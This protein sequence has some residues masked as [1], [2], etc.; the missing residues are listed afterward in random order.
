M[1]IVLEGKG[2]FI[3]LEYPFPALPEEIEISEPLVR[4]EL[5][6]SDSGSKGARIVEFS[7]TVDSPGSYEIPPLGFSYFDPVARKYLQLSTG[8]LPFNCLPSRILSREIVEKG[9]EN[10]VLVFFVL[11]S[12]FLSLVVFKLMRKR[13]RVPGTEVTTEKKTAFIPWFNR[14]S[15]RKRNEEEQSEML[16]HALEEFVKVKG[17]NLGA[18][19]LKEA[20]RIRYEL[21]H[22]MYAKAIDKVKLEEMTEQIFIL[23]E[24]DHSEY[25]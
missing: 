25:L 5:Y 9:K 2:N 15:I 22:M 16:L 18:E 1:R 14:E 7:F 24:S 21:Q 17:Q 12:L 10:S 11:L 6:H 8:P 19:H 20:K 13:K 3:N 23:F 4:D